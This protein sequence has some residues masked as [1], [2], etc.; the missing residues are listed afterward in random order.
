MQPTVVTG[1]SQR[2]ANQLC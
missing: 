2:C 1:I